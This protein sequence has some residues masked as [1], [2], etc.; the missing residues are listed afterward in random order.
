[1]KTRLLALCTLLAICAC[2]A[3]QKKQPNVLFLFIDDYTYRAVHEMGNK[4][5]ISPNLDK[6][7]QEGTLFTHAYNMG[8]WS[9]AVCTASRTMLNSG[10]TV[11]R[12]NANRKNWHEGDSLARAHT[13]AQLMQNAGYDTYMSGKWHVDIPAAD[14]FEQAEHVRPGMP[15]DFWNG[16]QVN[17]A[18]NK[19][20]KKPLNTSQMDMPKGYNRPLSENDDSWSPTDTSNGGFWAGGKHWSE[21]LKDDAENFI[22]QAAQK[23]KPFFM[24]LAFNAVHDP[25]QAPQKYQDL[26][27]V[28]KIEIPESFQADYPYHEEIGVGPRLRDEMLAPFPRT[29]LAIKTHL[30]EYY[31]LISHLDDQIGEILQ[32]LEEKGLRENTV[33]FLTADHGLAIGRHGLLGKQNMYDHSMRVP[34]LVAGSGIPKNKKIDEDVYLQ[35]IMPTA[36]D[37]TGKGVPDFVEFKSLMP[38]IHDQQGEAHL[39][40]VYGAYLRLQR[41]IRKDGY[42]LIVYPKVHK[43]LLFDLKNDPNEMHDL[44]DNEESRTKIESLF[45]DLKQMQVDLDDELNIGS[46]EDY[47]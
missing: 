28:D 4:Q 8:S 26:Y 36:L 37:L 10:L 17:E 12:A 11:W 6:L 16:K 31:A 13:W 18:I 24:Y 33:I 25:R 1:M 2:K 42:K 46:V 41:M 22:D 14:I 43:V 3:D 15:K 9:G 21:V 30:K 32:H 45:K 34:L 29:E 5:V 35:D 44:S 47:F 19:Y 38:L 23:Q 7:I 20:K 40:G 39:N 27:D